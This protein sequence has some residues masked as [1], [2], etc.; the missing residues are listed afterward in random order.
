MTHRFEIKMRA[1][2]E[3]QC[4]NILLFGP[5]R[6]GKTT[7]AGSSAFD[8]RTS[9]A[10]LLDFEG[11]SSSLA[12]IPP[13]QLQVV[14]I[15]NWEDFNEAYDYLTTVDHPF[16]TLI[17]DSLTEIHIFSLH[18]IVDDAI[19]SSKRRIDPLE[20]EQQDYG[21]SLVQIRRFLRLLR[22]LEMHCIFTAL[23]KTESVAREGYVQKP[24][25][26]GALANEVVGMFEISV[27]LASAQIRE[28]GKPE[29][30]QRTLYLQN[31]PGVRAGIRMGWKQEIPNSIIDPTITS[32]LDAIAFKE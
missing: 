16:K 3:I 28:K 20:I 27:Y 17:V 18:S 2:E 26:F 5:S 15:K 10:L 12:G 21:R 6:A 29:R 19:S 32:L 13:D 9:P 31:T 23:P 1:A 8:G 14:S 7:F 25:L 22:N 24:N 11:G 4:Y 30:T